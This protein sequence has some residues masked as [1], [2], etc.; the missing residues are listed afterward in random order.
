MNVN[1]REPQYP[2]HSALFSTKVPEQKVRCRD[3]S[4]TTFGG[5]GQRAFNRELG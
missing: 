1:S 2:R 3:L 4:L 5:D